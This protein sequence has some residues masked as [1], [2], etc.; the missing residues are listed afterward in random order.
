[1][2]QKNRITEMENAQHDW[3]GMSGR[4]GRRKGKVDLLARQQMLLK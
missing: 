3:R 4:L 1:M 2:Q